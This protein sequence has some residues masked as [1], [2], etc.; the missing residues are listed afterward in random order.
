MA[1]HLDS[2]LSAFLAKYSNTTNALACIVRSFEDLEYLRI[3]A[4]VGAIIGIHL[5]EPFISIT[6]STKVDY[7]K[8]QDTFPLL[9]HN[10]S[11]TEPEM[12]LDITQPAFSFTSQERFDSALYPQEIVASIQSAIDNYRGPIISVLKLL[13]PRLATSWARQRSEMFGFGGADQQ[14]AG[15]SLAKMD[16]EKL[17]TAPINNLDPERSVG[18]INHELK[19]RGAKQ[20]KAASRAHVKQQGLS[21]LKDQ[22]IDNRFL[23]L[24]KKGAIFQTLSS[25]GRQSSWI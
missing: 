16:Q 1:L 17:N 24:T 11:E 18:S 9:Y 13:L 7:T 5:V 8:L 22:T 2:Q 4:A 12:L 3:L 14:E 19:V 6:T 25:A 23:K 21:L 20:L 10:I 15:G